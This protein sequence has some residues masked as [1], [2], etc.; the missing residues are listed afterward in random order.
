VAS[1]IQASVVIAAV[2]EATDLDLPT[3]LDLYRSVGWSAYTERPA[4][5]AA[6]LAG[7][8]RVVTAHLGG[9]L[10][11]LARVISDGASIA[12]LQD[13][14]VHPDHRRRG[15]GAALVTAALA[16]YAAVRQHVLLTDDE[17][18]KRAFYE[19]LGYCEAGEHAA[20][21][22]RAFVRITT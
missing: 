14:L 2:T 13:L 3:V 22:L 7:S 19:S 16:P 5:L 6:A 9:Q 11:G 21:P 8:T 12:Y 15:T 17:P 10:V 4:A 1:G 18:A 20:G